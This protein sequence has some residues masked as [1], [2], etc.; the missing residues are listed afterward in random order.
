MILRVPLR[1]KNQ[2]LRCKNA[3]RKQL[4]PSGAEIDDNQI[5]AAAISLLE[6]VLKTGPGIM[7]DEAPADEAPPRRRLRVSQGSCEACEGL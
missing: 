2:W 1:S 6:L 3:I 7:P 5:H 4:A